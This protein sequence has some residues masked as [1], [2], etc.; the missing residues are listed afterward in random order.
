[1]ICYEVLSRHRSSV[2]HLI[3]AIGN[4]YSS[5][6]SALLIKFPVIDLSQ[7][8]LSYTVTV[9]NYVMRINWVADPVSPFFARVE[10]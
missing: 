4:L 3:N 8:D 9:F 5:H 10:A 7:R 6:S 1:M 2:L